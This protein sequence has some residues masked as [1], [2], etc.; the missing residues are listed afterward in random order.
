MTEPTPAIPPR[1]F[2]HGKRQQWGRAVLLEELSDR[3]IFLF[4]DGT[5]RAIHQE[6]YEKMSVLPC[7]PDE[8]H[9]IDRAARRNRP[10]T[11]TKTKAALKRPEIEFS[12]QVALFKAQ[13]PG[14]FQDPDYLVSERGTGDDRLK[15]AAIARAADVLSQD[16]LGE[17]IEEGNFAAV[18]D[19][20]AA[21]LEGTTGTTQR[22]EITRF[23][24][25]PDNA[26]ENFARALQELLYGEGPLVRRFDEYVLAMRIDG[27][28]S[29]PAATWLPACALPSEFVF[30]KPTYFKKQTLVLELELNYDSNPNGTTYEQFLRAATRCQERLIAAGLKP[31]DLMDVAAFVNTTLTPTAIRSV[32]EKPKRAKKEA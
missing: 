17:L 27:G 28:A 7:A 3:R 8:A 16:A 29:W 4:E 32:S 20:A 9:R 30:V 31:R 25:M 10:S 6:Y 23:R 14:G 11:S 21:C 2:Q 15:D 18:L 26:H 1:I 5:E 13:F 19:S 24:T 12:Q 22:A